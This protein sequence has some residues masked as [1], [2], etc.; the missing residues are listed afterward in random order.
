[1]FVKR[2]KGKFGARLLVHFGNPALSHLDDP[3][4]LPLKLETHVFNDVSIHSDGALDNQ[5]S[6]FSLGAGKFKV[7][8][9]LANG[10][11]LGR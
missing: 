7:Y 2:N 6:R 5:P 8:Q 10:H 11:S 3:V 4:K 9:Q 1:M